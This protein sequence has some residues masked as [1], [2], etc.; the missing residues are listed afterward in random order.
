MKQ[1]ATLIQTWAKEKG[2]DNIEKQELKLIEELGELAKEINLGNK[3]NQKGEIGD[4]FVVLVVLA[5]MRNKELDFLM[6]PTKNTIS[7]TFYNILNNALDC[8][9]NTAIDYLNDLARDLGHDL[10]EC[11]QMAYDKISKRTGQTID[12]Q[13]YKD[14]Q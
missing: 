5:G 12:G 6:Y 7:N 8:L 2:I 14:K 3:E 11:A 4:V 9:E 1:L 10:E 13:F